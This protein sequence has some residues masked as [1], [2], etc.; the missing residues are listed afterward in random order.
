MNPI[1][2]L[3]C[4]SIFLTLSARAADQPNI[5]L[6]ITDDQGYGDLACHGNLIIQTPNIDQ[7]YIESL[8]LTDYHVSPTCA[9]TC[10]AL[11]C[12]Q[13][14]DKAGPW[15]TINGRNY[16]RK[17]K[18]TLPETLAANGYATGHFGKWHL[19]DNYPY[20]PH[21]RGFQHALY[22]GG[23]GVGQTPDYF[24]NDYDEDTYFING[25]PIKYEGYCTDI[26]FGEAM[27]WVE[28]NKD[29]PFFAYITT[30]APHS[31]FTVDPKY[32]DLYHDAKIPGSKSPAR[33]QPQGKNKKSGGGINAAFYGMITNIDENFG[34]ME[35]K[36][37]E[38]G[39]TDNTIVIFTTD[40]GSSAGSHVFNVG[41]SGKKGSNQE[42]DHRVPFLIRW[43]NGNIEGGK[44][45]TALTAHID[46]MPTLLDLCSVPAPENY[47]M[48]GVS[49][50]PLFDGK[51]LPSRI[52]TTDSQ[53]I[54]TPEKWKSTA[55][56]SDHWRLLTG[57]A[58]YNIEK[59]PAQLND[60]AAEHPEIV[61]RLTD[62]YDQWWADIEPGFAE[63]T[64]IIVGTEHE[65]PSALTSH[66]WRGEVNSLPW[67]QNHIEAGNKSNGYWEAV[68]AGVIPVRVPG[69]NRYA[70]GW[71]DFRLR[72]ES[73]V[74]F[75]G[76]F[77][78]GAI[79]P[80]SAFSRVS[81]RL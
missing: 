80:P 48:D 22:H 67:N 61:K 81:G 9:P 46:V 38:L 49:L 78:S 32:S 72:V 50:R 29:K 35:E 6:V 44:D 51:K 52:I 47:T 43:P 69:Q 18:K 16:L 65:N 63:P 23:G 24:G 19:G 33:E 27:K 54:Y 71:F 20:R 76:A 55:V 28:K 64:H 14:T 7:F 34:I 42:G 15:H 68:N 62:G 40:N 11:M 57:G 3:L 60:V 12:G 79:I 41:M 10:G 31:P 25:E 30:N 36:L 66:D 58:L 39:L 26:W 74:G 45:I 75:A 1:Y 17:E 8:R 77:R 56:M 37:A 73:R 5:I 2:R 4:L 13:P 21:D 70:F 53:R 59:D